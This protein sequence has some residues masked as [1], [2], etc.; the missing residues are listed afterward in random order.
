VEKRLSAFSLTEDAG[1]VRP[2]NTALRD[3][4]GIG[5]FVEVN[6]GFR[7]LC[8]DIT[9]ADNL[10]I[11]SCSFSLV[12]QEIHTDN[13]DEYAIITEQEIQLRDDTDVTVR[14]VWMPPFPGEDG[15]SKDGVE[16]A[17]HIGKE[18]RRRTEQIARQQFG[19]PEPLPLDAFVNLIEPS[20][21]T[22][23]L[24]FR[25]DGTYETGGYSSCLSPREG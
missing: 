9:V 13:N 23:S 14:I 17:M 20:D 19:V 24:N 10:G 16:I 25:L 21:F 4:Q 7:G 11:F 22:L 15:P 3:D 1:Y 12:L 6:A 5:R 2:F 8:F 18:G